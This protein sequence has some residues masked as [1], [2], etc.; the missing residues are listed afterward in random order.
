MSEVV[1]RNKNETDPHIGHSHDFCDANMFLYDVFKKYGMDPRSQGRH[2]KVCRSME[3][4]VES[5]QSQKLSIHR[6][7]EICRSKTLIQRLALAMKSLTT[8]A[9][10]RAKSGGT[11]LPI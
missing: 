7:I 9:I 1:E 3:L 4:R 2:E 8:S 6:L 11:A 5:R 10:Y